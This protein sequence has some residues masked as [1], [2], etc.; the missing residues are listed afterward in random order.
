MKIC[1]LIGRARKRLAFFRAPILAVA[2]AAWG[3]GST[4]AHAGTFSVN[5]VRVTLSAKQ[6]VAAITVRNGG[7]EPAVVQL[8]SSAW[9]QDQGKDVLNPNAD[10]LATPPIFT[11]PPGGSQIVRVG[12][13]QARSSSSES[14]YRL[15]LREVPPANKPQGVHVTLMISMP[16]FVV[17]A[18]PIKPELVWSAARVADGKVRVVATNHGTAHVQLGKLNLATGSGQVVGTRT[19][20]EYVL[21]GNSKSWLVDAPSGLEASA[22]VQ[23]LSTSDAGDLKSTVALESGL[24]ANPDARS[25]R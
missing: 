10:L 7:T 5:P 14:T 25:S 24:A 17:P 8:E 12:L 1:H 19:V 11:L 4:L 3:A 9:T 21:P 2:L 18:T 22:S 13:R 20:S 16:V 15:V 6:P 23:I